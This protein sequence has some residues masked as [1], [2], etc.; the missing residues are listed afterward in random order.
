MSAK[1]NCEMNGTNSTRSML[2]WTRFLRAWA[3]PTNRGLALRVNSVARPILDLVLQQYSIL[4]PMAAIPNTSSQ[5]AR[6]KGYQTADPL[7]RIP[8]S[9]YLGNCEVSQ[10]PSRE[11]TKPT[12]ETNWRV[13]QDHPV[14]S[15]ELALR[16]G[17]LEHNLDWRPV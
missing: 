12:L 15:A 14:S 2:S 6:A 16:M 9:C 5:V 11:R 10:P 7:S 13:H 4:R 17:V 1:C 3:V 8:A